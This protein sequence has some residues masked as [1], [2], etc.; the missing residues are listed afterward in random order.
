MPIAFDT[1]RPWRPWVCEVSY[2]V[3]CL[4]LLRSELVN[5]IELFISNEDAIIY[6]FIYDL[7]P[8]LLFCIVLKALHI[9][10][11]LDLAYSKSP[12]ISNRPDV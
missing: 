8:W 3:C 9:A 7:S 11:H 1:W 6:S 4:I 12:R 2:L 5:Y 10:G